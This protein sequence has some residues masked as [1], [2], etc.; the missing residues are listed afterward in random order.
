ML[1]VFNE[2]YDF[3]HVTP[4]Y[5]VPSFVRNHF[6]D[7]LGKMYHSEGEEFIWFAFKKHTITIDDLK[8]RLSDEAIVE[9]VSLKN[10]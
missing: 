5:D 9:P 3:F 2:K 4:S 6:E 10:N 1:S 8:K 7:Y